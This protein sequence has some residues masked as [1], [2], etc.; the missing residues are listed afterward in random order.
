MVIILST[1]IVDDVR[2]LCRHMAII[3]KGRVVL[4]GDPEAVITSLHG[5]LWR[6]SVHK[7]DLAAVRVAHTVISE[8]LVG[9]TPVV[10]AV[11]DASPGEGWIAVPP[12]LE[13]VYFHTVG[14]D[15]A[16]A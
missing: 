6:R 12:D 3:D 14:A 10:H 16:A 5:R 1:H 11:A 13:D 15:A 4:S 2:E 9:G 8:R 7:A